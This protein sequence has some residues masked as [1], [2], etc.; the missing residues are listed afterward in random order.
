[1]R[2]YLPQSKLIILKATPKNYFPIYIKDIDLKISSYF[3][4]DSLK[5]VS[6]TNKYFHGLYDNHFWRSKIYDTYQNFP[7]PLD[8]IDNEK[9]KIKLILKY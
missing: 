1:M 4:D 5:S 8:Y 2:I 6:Q 3:N 9:I 7:I